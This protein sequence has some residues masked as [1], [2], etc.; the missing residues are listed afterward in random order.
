MAK[1]RRIAHAVFETPDVE[2]QVAYHTEMLGLSLVERVKD[3][4]Y[5]ASTLDHHSVIIKPGQAAACTGLAFQIGPNDDLA[6]LERQ[7]AEWGV[8]SERRS[9]PY[10]SVRETLSFA[11]PKGTNVDIFANYETGRQDFQGKGIVPHKL[12]HVAFMVA[13]IKRMVEFYSKL[14]GFRVSDWMG[15]FFVF[16]RCGPDHHTVNFVQAKS[17]KLHH[18]AFELRDWAHVQQACDHLGRHDIRMVWG[19]GRHGIG[20]NIFTYHR[21]P[22]GQ[23]TELFTELDQMK[24]EDLGYY[25]PRPWHRDKPQRPKVWTPGPDAVNT[26]GDPPPPGLLD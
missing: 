2:R 6:E 11:D 7:L 5:L 4:A 22:D 21:N 17:E 3:R 26:W 20:H 16:M 12:G 19:P 24:D 9:D 8:K 14:F 10:P 25:E 1:V 15:D 13:D 18:I 23:L